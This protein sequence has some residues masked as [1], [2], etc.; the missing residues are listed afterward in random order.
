MDRLTWGISFRLLSI[1]CAVCLIGARANA[2]DTS[3][4]NEEYFGEAESLNNGEAESLSGGGGGPK[5][6]VAP[7]WEAYKPVESK[8]WTT[9][10]ADVVDE[11]GDDLLVGARDM[12]SFCPNYYKLKRDNKITAWLYIISAIVKYESYFN[13]TDRYEE[14]GMGVDPITGKNIWSEGLLQLSYQDVLKFPFCDEFDWKRDRKLKPDSPKKTI[15]DPYKNLK[16]GIRILNDQIRRHQ[17]IAINDGAYWAVIMPRNKHNRLD[18]IRALTTVI[19]IC[20]K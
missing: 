3:Y 15:L 14:T 9:F 7:I 19:P 16:C 2:T 1:F 11:Y 12:E 13:P 17:Q 6:S 10:S 20:Q 4:E 8:P 18:K 5:I